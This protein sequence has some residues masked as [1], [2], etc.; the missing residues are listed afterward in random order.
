M[1][2]S[3][4]TRSPL[5]WRLEI[6]RRRVF[7]GSYA[8]EVNFSIETSGRAIDVLEDR[9]SALEEIIAARWPRSMILRRR[10]ARKL[11]AS[12]AT[13]AWAGP[14]FAT[15]RGEAMSEE[16]QVRTLAPGLRAEVAA[17]RPYKRPGRPR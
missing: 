10:L 16:I 13:F 6:L 15:R 3:S 11:R 8:P 14:D 17:G 5:R 9:V 4:R 1:K 7:V 2:R 12:A